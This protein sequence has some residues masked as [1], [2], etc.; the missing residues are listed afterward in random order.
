MRILNTVA[1]KKHMQR[2][3][4]V[5][6]IF[7]LLQISPAQMRLCIAHQTEQFS[8]TALLL[9]KGSSCLQSSWERNISSVLIHWR[10]DMENCA[11]HVSILS[12]WTRWTSPRCAHHPRDGPQASWCSCFGRGDRERRCS[13]RQTPLFPVWQQ[14]E[15]GVDH[16]NTAST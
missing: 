10:Q 13:P 9:T 16:V 14:S 11:C 1:Q 2:S 5:I 15:G 8:L 4:R 7:P 12:S 6:V 3:K